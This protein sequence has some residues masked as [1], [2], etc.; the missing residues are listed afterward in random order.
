[1]VDLKKMEV[2]TACQSVSSKQS[3]IIGS[4]KCEVMEGKSNA[5]VTSTF[6]EVSSTPDPSVSVMPD[7]GE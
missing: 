5:R 3:S 6:C 1:M 4:W 2:R 7:G